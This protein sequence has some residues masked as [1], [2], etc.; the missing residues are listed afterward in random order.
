MKRQAE[1]V[2]HESVLLRR[3]HAVVLGRLWLQL[4]AGVSAADVIVRPIHRV[5]PAVT[6][7]SLHKLLSARDASLAG[8]PL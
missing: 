2:V 3:I 5:N 6:S 7:L 8:W 4:P 1:D